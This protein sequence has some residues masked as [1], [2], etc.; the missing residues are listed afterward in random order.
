MN[1]FMNIC[2]FLLFMDL[3]FEY[4]TIFNACSKNKSMQIR[5]TYIFMNVLSKN[6]I[7]IYIYI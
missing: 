3:F 6:Y 1:L 4:V 2:V 5:R 7:Y